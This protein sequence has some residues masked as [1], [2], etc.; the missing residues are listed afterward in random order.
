MSALLPDELWDEVEPL[1]PKHVPSPLGGAPRVDDRTALAGIILV[2]KSGLAWQ[3]FPKELG[4]SGSTCW[5]RFD[6]WTAA[7]VW[8]QLLERLLNQLGKRGEIDLS[9]VVVD[10]AS[11]RALLGGRTPARTRPIAA[12][13]A[14]NVTF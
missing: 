12:N 8:P 14:S 4:C 1:L 13:G 2:L 7:G 3:M 6:E 5:R 11:I 10:S 9:R